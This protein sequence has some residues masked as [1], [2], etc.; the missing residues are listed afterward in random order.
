MSIFFLDADAVCQKID[1]LCTLNS[2]G[3]E[4]A[5]ICWIGGLLC[6]QV[7]GQNGIT[8]IWRGVRPSRKRDKVH[9]LGVH[10]TTFRVGKGRGIAS[11]RNVWFSVEQIGCDEYPTQKLQSWIHKMMIEMRQRD[12]SRVNDG[13]SSSN[14][15]VGSLHEVAIIQNLWATPERLQSLQI[16]YCEIPQKPHLKDTVHKIADK[17]RLRKWPNKSHKKWKIRTLNRNEKFIKDTHFTS[18][19]HLMIS[20]LCGHAHAH[21]RFFSSL[22]KKETFYSEQESLFN[23]FFVKS[24]RIVILRTWYISNESKSALS[25]L[26]Y[27]DYCLPFGIIGNAK[28]RSEKEGNLRLRPQNRLKVLL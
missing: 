8:K 1:L 24:S 23:E 28:N 15:T 12:M 9:N 19:S 25:L 21:Q 22:T 17:S 5:Y 16:L 18:S 20:V 2:R 14:K 11:S 27:N 3:L 10:V 6:W 4:L 7:M 13:P 26:I